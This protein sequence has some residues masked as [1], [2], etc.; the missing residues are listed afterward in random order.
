MEGLRVGRGREFRDSQ[1]KVQLNKPFSYIILNTYIEI[2]CNYIENFNQTFVLLR[3]E[4]RYKIGAFKCRHFEPMQSILPIY[5]FIQG[6]CQT[7][8]HVKP[9]L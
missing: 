8:P 6:F 2:V 9:I 7:Q 5:E 3:S 1:S 4:Q